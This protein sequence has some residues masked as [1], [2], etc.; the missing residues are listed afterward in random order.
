MLLIPVESYTQSGRSDC[1]IGTRP[2]PSTQ[3]Q[4]GDD[5]GAEQKSPSAEAIQ[6]AQRTIDIPFEKHSNPGEHASPQSHGEKVVEE[7]HSRG[8]T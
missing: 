5:D 2:L 6:S 4:D 7:K 3:D 1:P 8:C